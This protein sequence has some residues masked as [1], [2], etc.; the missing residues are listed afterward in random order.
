MAHGM[1]EDLVKP[2]LPHGDAKQRS[3]SLTPL[4]TVAFLNTSARMAAQSPALALAFLD[5]AEKGG[6]DIGSAAVSFGWLTAFRSLVELAATPII[7]SWSDFVGRKRV[8]CLC[9]AS[10]CIECA[11]LANAKSLGVFVLV[12]TLGGILASH[13]AIEGCC[14]VDAAQDKARADAFGKLFIA[15]GTAFI[16]GPALGGEL[17]QRNRTA[18]FAA[19]AGISFLSLTYTLVRLPEYLAGSRRQN[20]PR[21]RLRYVLSQFGALLSGSRTLVWY[22]VAYALSGLGLSAFLSTRILWTRS[23]FGWDGR[24]I[25]R[26]TALYG[27]SL[28]TAQFLLLPLLLYLLQGREALLAQLC[29]LVQTSRFLAYLFAPS[30]SWV[31]VA[32]VFST[33][34]ICSVPVLQALCSRHVPEE[35]QALLSGGASALNTAT[36]AVG[37]IIG[38]QLFAMAQHGATRPGSHLAFCSA[39]FALAAGCIS[40]AKNMPQPTAQQARPVPGSER[41][42]KNMASEERRPMPDKKFS[43]VQH[44]EGVHGMDAAMPSPTARGSMLLRQKWVIKRDGSWSKI[45][46]AQP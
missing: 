36:Q 28:V 12:H 26:I 45:D 40:L 11:V 32:L 7:T 21:V 23:L 1:R 24:E 16:A 35:Q 19:A 30:G 27:L 18:P 25:G 4:F 8:L 13:N 20:E 2:L 15:L 39:C 31:L 3:P 22:L 43:W 10:T 34:G 9:C 33:A 29:L 44:A 6:M 42:T 46:G 17:S 41:N 38:S 14:V 37:A 5:L